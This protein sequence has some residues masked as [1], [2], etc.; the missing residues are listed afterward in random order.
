MLRKSQQTAISTITGA[1]FYRIDKA[2]NLDTDEQSTPYE[3][4]IAKDY[5]LTERIDLSEEYSEIYEVVLRDYGFDIDGD[6]KELVR[7]TGYRRDLAYDIDAHTVRDNHLTLR[8]SIF[9][10]I[11]SLG[12]MNPTAVLDIFA[13]SQDDAKK[14]S[15][16]QQ[17][18]LE[19]YVLECQTH[20]KT[21]YFTY[22][23][24]IETLVA[25]YI[26][27]FKKSIPTELHHATEHLSL[28]EKIKIVARRVLGGDLKTI[29]LW[30]EFMELFKSVKDL[31][32]SI[33]H[34][35]KPVDVTQ[36]NVEDCFMCLATLY[37]LLREKK[38]TFD[39][40]RQ[41]LFPKQT[42]SSRKIPT[43]FGYE[44]N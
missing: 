31:R 20:L 6:G 33:A 9:E 21:G 25:E 13:L 12:G 44:K 32:N 18:I 30:G 39:E 1:W 38:Q 2:L 28:D 3:K 8:G 5:A 40:V 36:K 15:F 24:A 4:A 37:A 11:G 41:Y 42:S 23:S 34:G 14:Q 26:E 10:E 16:L 17:L 19:G 29:P 27:D 35:S 7:N 43:D 22:F